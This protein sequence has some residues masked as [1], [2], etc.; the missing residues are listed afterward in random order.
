MRVN[1]TGF[2]LVWVYVDRH[3]FCVVDMHSVF[4]CLSHLLSA[5]YAAY[6]HI[7]DGRS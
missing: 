1:S 4:V 7:R 5:H 2:E 6:V 3:F